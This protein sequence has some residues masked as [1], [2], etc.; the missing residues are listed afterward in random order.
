MHRSAG[1][2][3]ATVLLVLL[4]PSAAFPKFEERVFNQTLDHFRFTEVASSKWSHRYLYSE[5]FWTGEGELANGCKGPILLYTGNEGPIENFWA[6]TGFLSEVLA[7]KWKGLLVYPEERYFGKSLPFGNKSLDPEN[8]VYLS[9]E[10]VLAD[11]VELIVH[12][13]ATLPGAANCPVVS[14]GGSYG[15][16]LTTYLRLKYPH[17]VAGGLAASSS[18]G[19]SAPSSWAANGVDEFTWIDIVNK[20]YNEA[21][22]QCLSTIGRITDLIG[23]T[24]QNA[25]GRKSLS[26]TFH[27]CSPLTDA[28]SVQSLVDWWTDAIES[29]PQMNYPYAVSPFTYG[30]PVNHTC[31]TLTSSAALSSEDSVLLAASKVADDFYARK[32][33]A[34]VSGVGQGGIP[35]GGACAAMVNDPIDKAWGYQSCTETLHQVS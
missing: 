32:A 2:L 31:A 26:D 8:A 18:V 30:W 33:G 9:T 34:C 3:L 20:V 25:S 11:Y 22:P 19:Y 14:F 16:K 23:S 10:Q 35:G 15:A 6:A 28:A 24:G 1:L 21:H 13:K 29:M 12:L 7:P 17:I 5:E 27:L 4:A